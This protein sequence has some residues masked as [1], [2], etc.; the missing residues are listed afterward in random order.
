MV[1]LITAGIV[2]AIISGTL[3]HDKNRFVLG[4]CVVGALAPPIAFAALARRPAR[5]RMRRATRWR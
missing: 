1:Y 3:A 2:G 5:R 4:W